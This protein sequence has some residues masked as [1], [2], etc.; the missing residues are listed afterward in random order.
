V[1]QPTPFCGGPV[2]A[3]PPDPLTR[4]MMLADGVTEIEL[5]HLLRKVA[6]A[7]LPGPL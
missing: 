1:L 2:T 5:S 7:R 4:L 3:W 6:K